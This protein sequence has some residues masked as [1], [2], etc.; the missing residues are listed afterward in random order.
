MKR[1]IRIVLKSGYSFSFLCDTMKV[2]KCD[3]NLIGY[4]FDGATESLPMYVCL[5]SVDAIIDEGIEDGG[6]LPKEEDE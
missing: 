5:E 2:K 3:G 1:K 4:A 6:E